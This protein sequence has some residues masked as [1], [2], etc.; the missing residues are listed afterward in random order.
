MTIVIE[1]DKNNLK[2]VKIISNIY[3]NPELLENKR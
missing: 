1:I 2:G 3:E